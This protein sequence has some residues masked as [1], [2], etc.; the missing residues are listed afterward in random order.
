MRNLKERFSDRMIAYGLTA[1]K[2]IKA[3][4]KLHSCHVKGDPPDLENGWY[5]LSTAEPVV[6]LF[7]LWSQK[8]SRS[9]I[10]K[11]L[12]KMNT[13]EQ[14]AVNKKLYAMRRM[15]NEARAQHMTKVTHKSEQINIAASSTLSPVL[16]MSPE[17]MMDEFKG[18]G[19]DSGTQFAPKQQ[20]RVSPPNVKG[21]KGPIKT[22][23]L[24]GLQAFY[25]KKKRL[26]EEGKAFQ[27]FLSF[28][29]NEMKVEPKPGYLARIDKIQI[30]GDEKSDCIT[31]KERNGVKKKK[32]RKYVS[33]QFY[34]FKQEFKLTD[35]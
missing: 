31:I 34:A 6:G 10:S 11:P 18:K 33:S 7:G 35:T 29:F 8:S 9:W 1:P 2:N 28:V 27:E 3:D 15:R 20:N 12:K 16:D 30:T 21:R 22:M 25:D 24:G 13:E 14:G 17:N 5:I 32:K 19:R 26:P 4:R 23:V